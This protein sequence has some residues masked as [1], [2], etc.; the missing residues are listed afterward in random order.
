MIFKDKR[1]QHL[2]ALTHHEIYN[3]IHYTDIKNLSASSLFYFNY[4]ARF[5]SRTKDYVPQKVTDREQKDFCNQGTLGNSG[6]KVILRPTS[7]Q[8]FFIGK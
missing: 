6:K 1:D 2:S 3:P 8:D 7:H 5:K 4:T